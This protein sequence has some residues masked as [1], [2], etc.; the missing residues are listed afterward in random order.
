MENL[1]MY[2][3]RSIAEHCASNAGRDMTKHIHKPSLLRV[4]PL[5][6]PNRCPKGSISV[7]SGLCVQ[8]CV[9][10]AFCCENK[11]SKSSSKSLQKLSNGE[12]ES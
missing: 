7:C 2:G 4:H 1:L 9:S 11:S 12:V 8:T 10:V 5:I 3:K 6:R